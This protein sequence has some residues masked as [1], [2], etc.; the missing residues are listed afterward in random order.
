[1]TRPREPLCVAGTNGITN[2]WCL[3]G[4]P[5]PNGSSDCT[6]NAPPGSTCT[7]TAYGPWCISTVFPLGSADLDAGP[8]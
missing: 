4:T 2:G 5:C 1:V 6:A 3:G 7:Q 8:G